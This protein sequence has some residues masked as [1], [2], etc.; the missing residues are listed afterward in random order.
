MRLLLLVSL[1]FSTTSII[2]QSLDSI[3]SSALLIS[4]SSLHANI[5]DTIQVSYDERGNEISK[6]LISKIHDSNIG[7]P[8]VL[9]NT[10]DSLDRIIK[11]EGLAFSLENSA[12]SI[13]MKDTATALMDSILVS[14]E[15]FGDTSSLETSIFTFH[16]FGLTEKEESQTYTF[17][18][19]L[20]RE[21]YVYQLNPNQVKTRERTIN[22]NNN[23][24]STHQISRHSDG[25][26]YSDIRDTLFQDTLGL[27]YKKR[28]YNDE[29]LKYKLWST[30][31]NCEHL[32]F[33]NDSAQ[34]Y[35]ELW[36]DYKGTKKKEILYEYEGDKIVSKTSRLFEGSNKGDSL[37]IENYKYDKNGS[38]IYY[39]LIKRRRINLWQKVIISYAT[40]RK[41]QKK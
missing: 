29:N 24:I 12:S 41:P 15:Y 16:A 34:I 9:K 28:Y 39:E 7:V 13:T 2:A 17:Y 14:Y 18:D 40:R 31:G 8:V 27:A 38:V 5:P 33:R 30:C 6:I 20:G 10:Y 4:Y 1:Y 32:Y 19:S 36:Q 3:R 22:Y 23:L 35:R 26:V 11:T 21:N 37:R 25:K